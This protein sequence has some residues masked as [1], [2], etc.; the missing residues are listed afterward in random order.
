MCMPDFQPSRRLVRPDSRCSSSSSN[1][2]SMSMAGSSVVALL[3][4]QSGRSI[5]QA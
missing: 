4:W 2:Q 3:I 1:E 5:V